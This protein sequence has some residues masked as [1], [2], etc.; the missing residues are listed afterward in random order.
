MQFT[1]YPGGEA[2]K[3]SVMPRNTCATC[4]HYSQPGAWSARC[5]LGPPSFM[6]PGADHPAYSTVRADNACPRWEAIAAETRRAA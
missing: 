5:R 4:L 3:A 1:A 2:Q 6:Q